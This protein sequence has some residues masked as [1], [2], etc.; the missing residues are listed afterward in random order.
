MHSH[1]LGCEW[2]NG[3]EFVVCVRYSMAHPSQITVRQRP[4]KR[5]R[6]KPRKAMGFIGEPL[7][8]EWLWQ[9]LLNDDWAR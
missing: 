6:T 9:P 7:D 1:G 5:P 8:S 4:A 3:L 2:F